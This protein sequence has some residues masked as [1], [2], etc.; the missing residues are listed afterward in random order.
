[1]TAESPVCTRCGEPCDITANNRDW[2]RNDDGTTVHHACYT[3]RDLPNAPGD[4][5][6]EWVFVENLRTGAGLIA[7]AVVI[8]WG[9]RGIEPVVPG[10]VVVANVCALAL[11]AYLVGCIAVLYFPRG[12]L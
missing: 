11:L 9:G 1:M 8:W 10:I 5:M 7:A 4:F 12:W 6:D 2:M 3:R